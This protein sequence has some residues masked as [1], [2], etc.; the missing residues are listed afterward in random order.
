M[1]VY[2]MA[3]YG[4][5]VYGMSVNGISQTDKNDEAQILYH[6]LEIEKKVFV[7]AWSCTCPWAT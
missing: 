1:A 5:S 4:M 6:D 3:V 7:G 2:G